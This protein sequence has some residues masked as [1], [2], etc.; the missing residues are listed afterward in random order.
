[1][2]Y[3]ALKKRKRSAQSRHDTKCRR[4]L[5][6]TYALTI[7]NPLTILLFVS[8]AGRSEVHDVPSIVLNGLGVFAGSLVIQLSLA[9]CSKHFSITV[10]LC[11]H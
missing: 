10:K 9:L 5:L 6:S 7:I 3:E 4:P 8:F 11:L 2:L 1:M